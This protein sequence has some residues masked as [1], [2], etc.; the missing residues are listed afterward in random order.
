MRVVANWFAQ[1]CAKSVTHDTDRQTQTDR[2]SCRRSA[3]A[4]A[5]RERND[6]FARLIVYAA[7][8]CVRVHFVLYKWFNMVQN[9]K[10]VHGRLPIR[11]QSSSLCH[12]HA[13]NAQRMMM[14]IHA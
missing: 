11:R 12:N 2:R 14:I 7:F 13:E 1:V 4:L 10:C 9:K 3:N 6:L 8:M 5:N